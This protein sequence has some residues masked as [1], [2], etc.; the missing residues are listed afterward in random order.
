MKRVDA[1]GNRVREGADFVF[2]T[3][4]H[5]AHTSPGA[6]LRR[7]VCARKGSISTAA[8]LVVEWHKTF[9]SKWTY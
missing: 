4:L 1:K 6:R 2:Q 7:K 3:R 9:G 8:H 5:V